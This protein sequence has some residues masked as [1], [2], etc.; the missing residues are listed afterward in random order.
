MI[1]TFG[2]KGRA[3]D[4]DF[5]IDLLRRDTDRLCFDS[6]RLCLDFDRDLDFVFDID[7]DLDRD[8]STQDAVGA[9]QT[10]AEHV[11]VKLP[12]GGCF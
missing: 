1:F 8:K 9:D 11:C 5:D 3:C 4:R 10:V 6:D 2:V 7:L 12:D